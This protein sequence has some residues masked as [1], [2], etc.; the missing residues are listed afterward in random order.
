MGRITPWGAGSSGMLAVTLAV[1]VLGCSETIVCGVPMEVRPHFD[2]GPDWSDAGK[3]LYTW[4]RCISYM[5]GKVWSMSGETA[6]L[7]GR[8]PFITVDCAGA[9]T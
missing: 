2:G 9:S 4:Q 7:L 5:Q 8:P 3:H 6:K 1:H